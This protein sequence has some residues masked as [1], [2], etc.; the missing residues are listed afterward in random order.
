MQT[1]QTNWTAEQVDTMAGAYFEGRPARCV[2]CEGF[3]YVKEQREPGRQTV[4]LVL[5][6]HRCGLQASFLNDAPPAPKW[7]EGEIQ[8]ILQ[9]YRADGV[10]R[11]QADRTVIAIQETTGFGAQQ[12]AE[13]AA[14]CRR[15]GRFFRTRRE[16]SFFGSARY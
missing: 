13:I 8:D 14:H 6:C 15:C 10:A 4:D 3:L 2:A 11:C 9:A 5:D 12:G 7:S 16:E 1:G